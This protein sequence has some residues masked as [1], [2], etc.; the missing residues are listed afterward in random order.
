MSHLHEG[1]LR[2]MQDEPGST[3]AEDSAHFAACDDCRRRAE[4]I[5]A[6]TVGVS[7]LLSVPDAGVE[8][9]VA[10]L[11]LRRLAATAP[12]TRPSGGWLTRVRERRAFRPVAA[13]ALALGLMTALMATGVAEK[14]VQVFEPRS[15]AAVSVNPETLNALPDLSQFGT[16]TVSQ[17][18]RFSSAKTPAQALT[19]S[20]LASLATPHGQ[21]PAAVKGAPTYETF[22]QAQGSFRFSAD[23]ARQYAASRGKTIPAMPAG[24]NNTTI[25]AT[26]GPGVLT[27]YGAPAS[28]AGTSAGD[29]AAPAPAGA[30]APKQKHGL[31]G[32]A[33]PSLA[34]VQMTTPRVVSDGATLKDLEAYIASLPGVP[35][36]LAAQLG[37]IGDPTSTLP[38]P[39]PTGQ[40][41]H[42]VD[43][44]GSKGLFVGDSTGLGAG[45]VWQKDGVLYA[46][47]GT[48]N[49]SEVVAIAGSLR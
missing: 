35:A 4:E 9:G 44:N 26:A 16:Y 2:R 14:A 40:G 25:S 37:A 38:V 27:I 28:L 31:G 33:I 8:P 29:S 12:A 22:T 19:G 13:S 41:S 42:P 21:L 10:L 49:E 6:E 1:A 20:G 15:F 17:Q 48:L 23:K 45:V 24:I 30:T 32:L 39:L 5:R 47:V 11:R 34:I 36:D 7:T 46:V 43:I 18:P 3:G